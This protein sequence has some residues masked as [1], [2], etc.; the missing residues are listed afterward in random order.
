MTSVITRELGLTHADFFRTLPKALAGKSF[1][2]DGTAITLEENQRRVTICLAPEGERRIGRL[3]LPVT[4]VTFAF[5][6]FAEPEIGT[7]MSH[8]E[9]HFQ[10]GGG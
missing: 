2:V 6:G 10:R 4:R 7:F 5:E 8:F 9:R 3:R 1:Q